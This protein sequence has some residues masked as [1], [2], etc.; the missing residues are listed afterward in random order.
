MMK[1]IKDIPWECGKGW[2][3]LI[4]KVA[5][6]IDSFNAAHPETPVEVSQ[7]KQ[8]FGGLRIYHYNAPEDIRLLIDNAVTASWHTCEKCGSTT[9]VTTNLESYNLTL[10]PVCR[11]E[12]RPRVITKRKST[13]HRKKMDTSRM[14]NLTPIGISTGFNSLDEAIVG[15]KN[16][17]LIVIGSRPSVG[18]TMFGLNVALNAAVRCRIPI[19]YFSLEM[20]SDYLLRR[21]MIREAELNV[22]D[23]EWARMEKAIAALKDSP[24]YIDDTPCLTV[25]SFKDKA[26]ELVADNDVKLIFIDYLQLMRGPQEYLGKRVEEIDYIVRTLK[27]TAKELDIPIIVLSQMNRVI[28]TQTG[29]HNKP[30]VRDLCESSSIEGHADLI[31][32][33]DRPSEEETADII[34]AKN[35]NGALRTIPMRFIRESLKFEEG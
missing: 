30:Q 15:W 12:I 28:R 14:K 29:S 11:K 34:I 31:L 27:E 16:S 35:R 23:I 20:K 10:C 22:E 8:K 24:F 13:I 9:G 2:W 26:K 3:P 17:E 5:A 32:L 21:I 7:I 1:S 6:A 25:N 33:I 4:E 18:K 19:A